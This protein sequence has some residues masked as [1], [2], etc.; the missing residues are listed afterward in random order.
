MAKQPLI[1]LLFCMALASCVVDEQSIDVAADEVRVV[2][3]DTIDVR[4]L[5]VRLTGF[6]A[7]ELFSA[8]CD[9]ELLAA[10]AAKDALV[11]LVRSSDT[12]VLALNDD[13]D[14]YGRGLGRLKVN[15]RDVA[16][17]IDLPRD[18]SSIVD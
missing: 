3:G 10:M 12:L 15:G 8:Q 13:R 7:P 9:I 6:D 14:R 17:T 18:F 4:G 2:D 11:D 16:H 5:R 1:P